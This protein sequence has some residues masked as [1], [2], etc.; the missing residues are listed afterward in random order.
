[1]KKDCDK[2]KY[3]KMLRSEDPCSHCGGGDSDHSHWQPKE[4]TVQ[5]YRVIKTIN[6]DTLLA[7]KPCVEEYA[8]YIQ[9][10]G[11]AAPPDV[12]FLKWVMGRAKASSDLV[13]LIEKGFIEKVEPEFKPLPCP[14]CG[15][16]NVYVNE[17]YANCS[18]CGSCSGTVFNPERHREKAI[19]LWNRRA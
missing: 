14:F 13:W 16:Q 19:E 9:W 6:A 11:Y 10:F 1:M 4:D 12:S 18:E 5:E 2:C 15:S 7:K 17:R 8:A 3:D